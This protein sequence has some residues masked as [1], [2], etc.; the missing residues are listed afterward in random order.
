MPETPNVGSIERAIQRLEQ[1][2]VDIRREQERQS[3][4]AG[5]RLGVFKRL[6]E[7]GAQERRASSQLSKKREQLDAAKVSA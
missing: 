1:K 3:E 5:L 2:L 7:L 6:R 4:F